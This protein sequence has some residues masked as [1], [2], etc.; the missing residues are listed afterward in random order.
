MPRWKK[1]RVT[2]ITRET[3][4]RVGGRNGKRKRGIQNEDAKRE[5]RV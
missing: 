2:I 3:E 4:K 5:R 1:E